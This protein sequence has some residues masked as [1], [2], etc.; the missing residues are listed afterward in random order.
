MVQR[1]MTLYACYWWVLRVVNVAHACAVLYSKPGHMS[2]TTY[3]GS[4]RYTILLVTAL[5]QSQHCV[6][7]WLRQAAPAVGP[8]VGIAVNSICSSSNAQLLCQWTAD[9]VHCPWV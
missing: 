1:H 3:Q 6:H 9:R 8:A 7:R 2:S 4:G 5:V